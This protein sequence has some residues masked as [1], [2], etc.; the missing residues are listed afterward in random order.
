M[1]R[2]IASTIGLGFIPRRLWGSDTGAGTFGA[3]FAAV[4]GLALLAF[5]APWWLTLAVAAALIL[6]SLW[7]A[8]PFAVDGEDPGWV[9][10]DEAAGTMVA[11]VGLGGIPWLV[12]L[13]VA[14]AAD[15]FK[16]LPG[17]RAAEEHLPGAMGITADDVVAGIYGLG[18]GWGVAALL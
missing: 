8:A 1:H 6:I 3:A 7:A 17:V 4:L 12:A 15:I 10:I 2:L 11:L 18:A 13:V 14:R 16:V 5:D 9:C